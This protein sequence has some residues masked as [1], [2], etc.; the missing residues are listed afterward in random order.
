MRARSK[1]EVEGIRRSVAEWRRL[2]DRLFSI[3]PF[4]VGLD[5]ILTWVPALGG[6]YGLGVGGFLILQ[7]HRARASKATLVKMGLLI[8]TDAL[9]GEIPLVGDAF[10]FFFRAHARS[11][12]LLLKHI[13]A[14]HYVEESAADAEATGRDALHQA[15]MRASKGKR[16]L[17]FL[18]D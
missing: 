16:R 17:A 5:G 4:G 15:D 7:A 1:T 12:N 6:V 2:S 14:T 13:D 10:D 9:L 8:G 3:G 18:Q 11:A